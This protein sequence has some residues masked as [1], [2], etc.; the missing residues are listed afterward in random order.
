MWLRGGGEEIAVGLRGVRIGD[1]SGVER[2]GGRDGDGMGLKGGGGRDGSGVEIERRRQ[3][4][5]RGVW[6]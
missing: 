2:G 5:L 4:G 3:C 6:G 1:G